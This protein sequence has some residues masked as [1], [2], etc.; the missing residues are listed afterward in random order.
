M[1][2]KLGVCIPYRNRKDHIDQLI[3]KLSK[4]LDAKGIEHSFYVGHQVDNKLFNRGSMKNI[5]AKIAFDDGCDYIA[6]HDVDMLPEMDDCDYSYPDQTPI[7]IATRL[8]KYAYSMGYEQY[9]GGVVLFTKEQAEQVNGYSNEYWDWG[10]EDDDLFWRCYYE[11]LTENTIS[12]RYE[13]KPIG[14]FNGV[15]SYVKTDMNRSISSC[16]HRDHTIS[17]LVKSDQQPEKVPIWLVGDENRK[18]IEYPVLR[19]EGSWSWGVSFN[20]S[21]A[22]NSL[23]FYRNN[24]PVYNWAKRHENQWTW[25][26][27]SYDSEKDELYI[28]VND[29]LV[30]N[31]GDV[32]RN[33]PIV[34]TDKFRSHNSYGPFILGFCPHTGVAFKGEISELRVYDRY[35]DNF[36]ESQDNELDLI[37][38]FDFTDLDNVELNGMEV[39]Q[40]T[41]E[42]PKTIL[43]YRRTGSF[44]CLPHIDEGFVNGKWAK[45]ETTARNEKRF[46][47]KMQ[48]GDIDYKNEGL[49]KIMDVLDII[50]I[51]ESLYPNTKF[52]NVEMK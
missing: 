1:S 14:R 32:L 30:S 22:Y 23:Y 45:G 13:N 41:V 9:F 26:T 33:K 47:T 46:V 51:D 11:Q 28:F 27:T 24:D 3:P 15:N 20:N 29:Q 35:F 21:R 50:E 25:Y 19:K 8:S 42:V 39:F 34:L 44:Y 49:N 7:H 6:W 31:N 48:Q 4:F 36:P 52:I 40:D 43:P 5:A 17:V 10:Q 12:Y 38:K 18:F 16:L 2:H 37:Y